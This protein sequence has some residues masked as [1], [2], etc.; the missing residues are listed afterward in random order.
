[1]KEK[2][3]LLQL[4]LVISDIYTHIISFT[5]YLKSV[6]LTR[7]PKLSVATGVSSHSEDINLLHSQS[8]IFLFLLKP[9]LSS[10]HLTAT[11]WT[12]S[13]GWRDSEEILRGRAI[14]ANNWFTP[15]HS[16]HTLTPTHTSLTYGSTGDVGGN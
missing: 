2:I 8:D 3:Y 9:L 15:R 4:F 12:L 14:A 13:G 6:L 5:F 10:A 7:L 16:H 11:R 1:M